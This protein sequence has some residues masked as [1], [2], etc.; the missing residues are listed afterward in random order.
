MLPLSAAELEF[1]DRLLEDG[2]VEPAL[3]TPD[4]DVQRR[5]RA[6]PLLEWKAQNIRQFRG[7]A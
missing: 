5:V 4:E 1:L 7:L 6:H 3:L 2:E